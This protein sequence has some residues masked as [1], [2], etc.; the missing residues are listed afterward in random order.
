MHLL[1]G[2]RR[3]VYRGPPDSFGAGAVRVLDSDRVNR[4]RQFGQRTYAGTRSGL[5]R[6]LDGG[7]SW[8]KLVVPQEEVFDVVECPVGKRLFVG[9]HPAHLYVSAD[10]G[11]SWSECKRLLESS[12]RDSWNTPRHRDEAHVR[13]LAAAGKD[14]IAAGIKVGGIQLSED[15]GET[16]IER[17]DGAHDDIHHILVEGDDHWVA[18][19]GDGLYRT[20]D[21][22]GSWTRLDANLDNR[23]FRESFA[24][25]GR[26]YAS[27]TAGPPSSWNGPSDTDAALYESDDDGTTFE[28][29]EYP[30]APGEFVLSWTATDD[31]VYAGTSAGA[32]LTRESDGWR[33]VGSISTEIDS[34]TIVE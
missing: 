23:Y 3:G 7:E 25:R 31:K 18:S 27:A 21:A 14:R 34:M 5:F 29:V 10:G 11:E 33:R 32:L 20:H 8:T 19:T 22:G 17:L 9:T 13:S 12:N 15:G 16:W 28:S 6:S 30:G 4:V 2:T 1:A 26:L 24:H